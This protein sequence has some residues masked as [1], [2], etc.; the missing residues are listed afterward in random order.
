[1]AKDKKVVGGTHTLHTTGVFG[2]SK[3]KNVEYFGGDSTVTQAG[4]ES[5]SIIFL[6]SFTVIFIAPCKWRFWNLLF[7]T[8]SCDQKLSNFHSLFFV[9]V[10]RSITDYAS[11]IHE[12][13]D[14]L[15]AI[16]LIS[17]FIV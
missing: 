5:S 1:M 13:N 15:C 6:I 4:K 9:W 10:K 16:M 12:K 3:K 8:N 17:N 2:V 7:V 14:V 11:F